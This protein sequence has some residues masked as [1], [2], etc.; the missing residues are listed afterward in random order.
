MSSRLLLPKQ[1][2]L[3]TVIAALLASGVWWVAR[4]L[5][6]HTDR[7][8]SAE[9]TPT[10]PRLAYSGPY[11]NVAS[12]VRYVGDSSCVDCHADYVRRFAR[13]PMGRSIH[14]VKTD[15]HPRAEPFVALGLRFEVRS[16]GSRVWHIAAP[17]GEGRPVA[18]LAL[19]A[20]YVIGS[21]ERGHSYLGFRD[22]QA[23]QTPISYYTRKGVWDL[24]PG[25][26]SALVPGR[27]VPASCL[28]CHSNGT[29]ERPGEE[30]RFE[31]DPFPHGASIGCERC[32][33]PAEIHVKT[34]TP[35]SIVNP[36]KLPWRLREATCEQCHLQGQ[37]RVLPRG[38]GLYD[39]RPGLPLESCWAVYGDAASGADSRA[40][41]HVEQMHQSR[42][43]SKS[44]DEK[45]L[46]CI[47]CHDPHEKPT[48]A[49]RVDHYRA[50]CLNCH[51]DKGC[52]IDKAERERKSP[53][54]SCIEC[55]MP[56]YDSNDIP[57]NAATNHRIPR[58][59]TREA[60][61]EP[62]DSVLTRFHP[63]AA[64][65]E[66]EERR[67]RG[68]ALV[69]RLFSGK[70]S[71]Q[72]DT[73]LALPLLETAIA[74]HPGDDEAWVGR[75]QALTFMGQAEAGLAAFETALKRQPRHELALAGKARTAQM[76][77]DTK[78]AI[79]A[80]KRLTDISPHTPGYRENLATLLAAV[81]R[82]AEA[83]EQ[84]DLWV[85]QA[86]ISVPARQLL[87]RCLLEQG[88]TDEAKREFAIALR[89]RPIDRD[90]LET[91]FA[92]QSK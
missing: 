61:P 85:R 81:G 74:A 23:L 21:G 31:A 91:W 35:G 66:A 82:W 13:H 73:A 8:T 28:F 30:D 36:G 62:G 9:D 20:D 67:N 25:F 12:S 46:G 5:P 54:D 17:E 15:D 42:C 44:P 48:K 1:L 11:L 60:M 7:P 79:D 51:Q 83:R 92:T 37:V 47:S 39:F 76:L 40:V 52:S 63:V 88:K 10:D 68:I 29:A 38:R 69:R 43:F 70:R 84:A 59:A 77:Q 65:E 26:T 27:P 90:V 6:T 19:P 24:S 14:A 4:L 18:E 45:K 22:G 16:K 71:Q 41:N 55:H 53:G 75:G 89:L 3:A 49:S 86:P 72:R 57:H 64:G 80:W 78:A 32:H 87:I 34:P 50:R 56:R 33:G 2:I 58:R